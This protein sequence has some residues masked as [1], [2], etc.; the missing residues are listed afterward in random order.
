MITY[1]K[2]PLQV[3]ALP[4]SKGFV[5]QSEEDA[6]SS[7]EMCSQFSRVIHQE[8]DQY[9]GEKSLLRILLNR[10]NMAGKEAFVPDNEDMTHDEHSRRRALI[11]MLL[12]M[13]PDDEMLAASDVDVSVEHEMN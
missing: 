4:V 2:S 6:N 10:N 8:D 11:S 13:K 7:E 1:M 9:W 3:F 5:S 12:G